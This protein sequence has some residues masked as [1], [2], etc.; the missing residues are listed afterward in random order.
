MAV[1]YSAK[2]HEAGIFQQSVPA[3]PL[4]IFQIAKLSIF[5]ITYNLSTI[6]V[7]FVH[8]ALLLRSAELNWQADWSKCDDVIL[9]GRS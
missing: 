6:P 9:Q 4:Q 3:K 1:E 7:Q 5:H 2:R 8:M